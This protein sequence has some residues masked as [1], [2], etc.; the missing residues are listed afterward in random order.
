MCS[1]DLVVLDHE[2]ERLQPL[3]NDF[4]IGVELS[5]TVV[6]TEA[7]DDQIE[8]SMTVQHDG[9]LFES[10]LVRLKGIIKD[11]RPAPKALLN[12][13][14]TL[15]QSFGKDA[16]PSLFKRPPPPARI[17]AKKI[18]VAKAQYMFHDK[19]PK[20]SVIGRNC[21]ECFCFGQTEARSLLQRRE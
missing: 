9:K 10:T 18:G 3:C 1:S 14:V 12:K 7:E 5:L 13:V 11:R 6:G 20:D 21:N 2:S 19:S 4:C 17:S 8:G 16:G 15:A